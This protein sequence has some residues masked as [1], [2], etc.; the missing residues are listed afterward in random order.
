MNQA[1]PSE[2]LRAILA[3]PEFDSGWQE[4]FGRWLE[5]G[6]RAFQRWLNDLPDLERWALLLVCMGILALL[7]VTLVA[8]Y[9]EMMAPDASGLKGPRD[10][11][12]PEP[13][14]QKLLARARVLASE[15]RLR[16][17]ARAL[18]QAVYSVLASRQ[19]LDWDGARADWEWVSRLGFEPELAAFTE[20]AQAIA[21]GAAA[22][23]GATQFESLLARANR[24]VRT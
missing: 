10:D 7:V 15:G 19:R 16:E 11:A 14:W 4:Q 22:D 2:V 17:A 12:A 3:D 21:Y 20:E 9:R 8:S 18:Q 23:S 1:D 5:Q 13:T 24:W 6:W